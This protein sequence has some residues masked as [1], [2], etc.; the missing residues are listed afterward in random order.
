MSHLDGEVT[1]ALAGKF[2]R[3]VV[4][5][6]GGPVGFVSAPA[7][8]ARGLIDAHPPACG[9]PRSAFTRSDERG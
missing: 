3:A 9:S 5:L 8:F 2:D 4:G 1:A 6:P 7:E